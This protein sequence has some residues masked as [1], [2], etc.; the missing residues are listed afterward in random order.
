MPF[1]EVWVRWLSSTNR[2][3]VFGLVLRVFCFLKLS[4]WLKFSLFVT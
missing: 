3:K 1:L 2:A 4:Q